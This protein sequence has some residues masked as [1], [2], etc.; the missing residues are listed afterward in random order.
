[1]RYYFEFLRGVCSKLKQILLLED[2]FPDLDEIER[3]LHGKFQFA[4]DENVENH[5]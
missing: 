1:M 3:K 4:V 2:S 5:V